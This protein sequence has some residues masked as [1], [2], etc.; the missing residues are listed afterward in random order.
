MG[1]EGFGFLETCVFDPS[2]INNTL[3]RITIIDVTVS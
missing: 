1:V 2:K 3:F